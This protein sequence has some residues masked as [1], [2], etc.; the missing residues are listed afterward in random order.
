MTGA[1]DLRFDAGLSAT[2]SDIVLLYVAL[3]GMAFH[4]E[5]SAYLGG[6][7]DFSL[8]QG[9]VKGDTTAVFRYTDAGFAD[10][11][12]ANDD[13][14]RITIDVGAGDKLGVTADQ[15]GGVKVELVNATLEGVL[16]A[17]NAR[18]TVSRPRAVEGVPGVVR[19]V[20]P[21]TPIARVRHGFQAFDDGGTHRAA[22]LAELKLDL[23][24]PPKPLEA[25][26]GELFIDAM[27]TVGESRARL[28]GDLSFAEAV[29]VTE[30]GTTSATCPGSDGF[31]WPIA[32][33][34]TATEWLPLIPPG[35]TDVIF[36]GG[37]DELYICIEA[38]AD[39]AIPAASY[40]VELD[41]APPT[42]TSFADYVSPVEDVIV[43]VGAIRR[44]GTTIHIPYVSTHPKFNQRFQIVNNGAATTYAFTFKT[45]EGITAA[46]GDAAT[47]D[48]PK[49]TTHLK[50][51]DV[52]TLTGGTRASATFTAVAMKSNIEM[53]SL[54]VARGSGATDVTVLTAE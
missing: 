47:G 51:A 49:G 52:V 11:A 27:I 12:D 45:E 14:D 5:V 21:A 29:R 4:D 13:S 33:D 32:E 23:P 17:G 18:T 35:Q 41:F 54:L 28:L 42:G 26:G 48:L 1:L 43:D 9:G 25:D 38:K 22:R 15:V 39:T 34:G 6:Q 16:G 8:I 7:V 30:E 19:T 31:P 24:A 40:Q 44:D 10:N 3:T 50:L 46:P 2:A 20:T 36:L 53:S 37:G